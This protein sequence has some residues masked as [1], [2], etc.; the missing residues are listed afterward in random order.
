MDVR[1]FLYGPGSEDA[2]A[3]ALR[4]L[5]GTDAVIIDLRRNGGGSP[6]AVNLLLSHFLTSDTVASLKV[7]N[8]SGGESFTR[9]TLAQ[10]PGPRRPNVPLYVLTSGLTASAGEDFA[11]VARN[12]GRAT[13]VGATTAGAGRN[14]AVLDVGHG[15][16][17][18]ISFTRVQDPRT[19]AEWERVGVK[20]HVE[21][22]QARALDVAHAMALDTLAKRDTS[23]RRRQTLALLRETVLAQAS[24]RAVPAGLLAEYAGEYDGGRTVSVDDAGRLQYSPR[25]GA[26]PEPLVP[27]TDSTFAMG[28]ARLAFERDGARVARLRVTLPDDVVAYRRVR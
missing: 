26:P 14:N 7:T 5:D 25:L 2:Y 22:D 13:L 18:S 3:A 1:G 28:T 8:R 9:Y 24:R 12:L 20:P 15:F 10:V 6:Q 23:A 21:V 27:L 11:F 19:G 16:G 4:Y 17:A